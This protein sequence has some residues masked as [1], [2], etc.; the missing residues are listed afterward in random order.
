MV[1]GP[2]GRLLAWEVGTAG[3]IRV[4]VRQAGHEAWHNDRN[5]EGKYFWLVP[6]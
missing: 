4:W 1:D 3:G 2:T 6:G 5:T